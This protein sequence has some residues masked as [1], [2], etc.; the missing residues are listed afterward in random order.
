MVFVASSVTELLFVGSV[1][2][3]PGYAVLASGKGIYDGLLYEP[4]GVHAEKAGAF[5]NNL[6]AR[7]LYSGC[8]ASRAR[9]FQ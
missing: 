5:T 4:G 8:C 1:W 6:T 2:A 9:R 7:G 3:Q